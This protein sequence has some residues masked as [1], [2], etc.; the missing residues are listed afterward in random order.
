MI[1]RLLRGMARREEAA[2][3]PVRAARLVKTVEVA[4]K[5]S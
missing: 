3:K 4:G 2:V 1:V 5:T